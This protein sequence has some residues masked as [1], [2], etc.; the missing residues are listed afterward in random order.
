MSTFKVKQDKNKHVLQISTLDEKHKKFMSEFQSKKN[1]LPEKKTKY[2]EIKNQLKE[3][4]T[5]NAKSFTDS[6]I[7]R[8][9]NLQLELKKLEEQIN[10]IEMDVSELDYYFTTEEIIMDYYQIINYND[11]MIYS[12][13]EVEVNDTQET[14]KNEKLEQLNLLNK[15]KFKQKK[16]SKRRPKKQSNVNQKNIIDFF[17]KQIELTNTDSESNTVLQPLKNKAEL[18]DQYMMIIDSEYLCDKK[19]GYG[20][21]KKCLQ[22]NIE[23]VLV[24]TD[25]MYVC[26]NC[27]E[28]EIVIIDSEKPNYKETVSSDTKPGYPYKRSNHLSEWLAQFQAKE[29][30]EIPDEIYNKILAELKKNR[31]T[32]LKA[33]GIK[34][35]KKILKTLDLSNYYEHTTFIISKL[36][37]IP[38]PTINRE[39]EDKIK[40]MFRQIQAPFDK[41]CPKDRTNFLSYSYVLHK[42]FQLLE[43][44]EFLKYFPLLKNR[45]KLKVQ[46]T[47]WENICY[48]LN[49]YFYPS[50]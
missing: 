28:S 21:I 14:V 40:L 2:D 11:D 4:E 25:G 13:E 46:D 27:G 29:S 18:F 45:E 20:K 19:R 32:N 6:D 30:I 37:G 50:V 10:D 9:S 1:M 17:S 36:S 38:P 31:I 16:I 34:E 15:S 42:F 23:K 3:F 39:T 49:W 7:R 24:Y 43:L 44:D 48:D 8:R 47:I 35:T 33:L 26:Q 5:T 22:C 41:H 12:D